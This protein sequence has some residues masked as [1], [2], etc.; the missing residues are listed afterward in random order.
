VV[1]ASNPYSSIS[2]CQLVEFCNMDFLT[3]SAIG[4][5]EQAIVFLV[6]GVLVIGFIVQVGSIA[7]VGG[8][9][10]RTVAGVV[11]RAT[12]F[13]IAMIFCVFWIAR[14]ALLLALRP[15]LP[16]HADLVASL[17]LMSCAIVVYVLAV[18]RVRRLHFHRPIAARI[19]MAG[20]LV[21]TIG[22][23]VGVLARTSIASMATRC[24]VRPCAS[25]AGHPPA[26]VVFLAG[27]GRT[28]RAIDFDDMRVQD[29]HTLSEPT[30]RL[31][32]VAD[33]DKAFSILASANGSGLSAADQAVT[34]FTGVGTTGGFRI[35]G[36][37]EVSSTLGVADLR[38]PNQRGLEVK[39]AGHSNRLGIVFGHSA[40]DRTVL[41]FDV[42]FFQRF[43][44]VPETLESWPEN[45]TWDVD[46]VTILPGDQV[47]FALGRRHIML[48][49]T[50]QKSVCR[51]AQGSC[52]IVFL[53]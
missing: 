46:H 31:W 2:N 28:V 38:P 32:V 10:M 25:R 4:P 33:S 15:L 41:G 6:P 14:I 27:D 12:G 17:V 18:L 40:Q 29:V 43:R 13:A 49:D 7:I 36:D 20:S 42:P 45:T 26:T 47:V 52:P 8:A 37:G 35:A 34:A 9:K 22:C 53:R 30:S 5:L 50:R 39:Q 19:A 21:M 3:L 1:F 16:I 44:L 24:A 11:L 48:L 51:L 23:T